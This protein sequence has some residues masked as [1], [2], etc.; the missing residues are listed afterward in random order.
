MINSS[1]GSQ[2]SCKIGIQVKPRFFIRQPD[3]QESELFDE[4]VTAINIAKEV[5]EGFRIIIDFQIGIQLLYP[6]E[7]VQISGTSSFNSFVA[8]SFGLYRILIW[9]DIRSIT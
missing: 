6:Q 7:T 9:P 4:V 3:K 2:L 5:A 1:S 8:L